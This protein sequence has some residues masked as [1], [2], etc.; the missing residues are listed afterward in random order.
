MQNKKT[1]ILTIVGVATLLMAVVGATFAF[2]VSTLNNG[3]KNIAVSTA[4]VS[5]VVVTNEMIGMSDMLPGDET[6]TRTISASANITGEIMVPYSCSIYQS[7]GSFENLEYYVVTGN[8]MSS[9]YN[10]QWTKI[11]TTSTEFLTGTLSSSSSNQTS[12]IK[13]RW[14]ETGTSQNSESGLTSTVY[15]Y[16]SL[17]SGNLYYNNETSLT[18]STTAPEASKEYVYTWVGKNTF[19][20]DSYYEY[21][22]ENIVLNSAIPSDILVYNSPE[23]VISAVEN[24]YPGSEFFVPMY[25]RHDIQNGVVAETDL[26]FTISDIIARVYGLNAGTYILKNKYG[27]DNSSENA[28]VAALVGTSNSESLNISTNYSPGSVSFSSDL[29]SYLC[30]LDLWS[31]GARCLYMLSD[32]E[33]KYVW[34]GS[35]SFATSNALYNEGQINIISIYGSQELDS[36]LIT[37]N[38]PEATLSAVRE[39]YPNMAF[40][41]P[42]YYKVLIDS[43]GEVYDSKLYFII[44]NEVATALNLNAGTYWFKT[45]IR[46]AEEAAKD[47]NENVI[48]SIS[49]ANS[50][51]ISGTYNGTSISINKFGVDVT[52]QS[53]ESS[54]GCWYYNSRCIYKPND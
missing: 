38:T 50:N 22:A 23:A 10:Q 36:N 32:R 34:V 49:K 24:A 11:T 43:Y 37:F 33:V 26:V 25:L 7:N 28:V 14:H 35:D 6:A 12:T 13:F 44:T 27:Q 29:G 15:V 41:I 1:M 48:K 3:T 30:D 16:C 31:T 54:Y 39:A 47:Y 4:R 20:T 51:S 18:G 9:T 19:A 17:N 53:D 45:T 5:N 40:T 8:G 2:F 52:K 46:E 21:D 42:T